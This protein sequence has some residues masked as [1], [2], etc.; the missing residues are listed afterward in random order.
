MKR[1]HVISL[2]PHLLTVCHRPT[3]ERSYHAPDYQRF[4][5]VGPG[6][7]VQ[8][9]PFEFGDALDTQLS[10][11]LTD[12]EPTAGY[13]NS[14]SVWISPWNGA[15]RFSHR[16]GVS[17]KSAPAPKGYR[18]SLLPGGAGTRAWVFS[19]VNLHAF[20]DFLNRPVPLHPTPMAVAWDGPHCLTVFLVPEDPPQATS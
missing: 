14:Y 13:V 11:W 3:V 12:G 7:L 6:E 19:L 5:V 17:V 16:R 9:E 20:T 2:N 15:L 18:W 4:S 1:L 10:V 8:P